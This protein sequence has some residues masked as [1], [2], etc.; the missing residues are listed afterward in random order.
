MQQMRKLKF[1][2][3]NFTIVEK[4]TATINQNIFYKL[5]KQIGIQNR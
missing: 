5:E 4:Y 1:Y 2:H 3:L